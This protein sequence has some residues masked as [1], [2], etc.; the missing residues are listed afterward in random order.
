M[1]FL[2]P[3]IQLIF[4][5]QKIKLLLV[6]LVILSN[7]I[8][9][10][11]MILFSV[12]IAIIRNIAQMCYAQTMT[13]LNTCYNEKNVLKL[14]VRQRIQLLPQGS[15]IE[16]ID[17]NQLCLEAKQYDYI[18]LYQLW[19][20]SIYNYI[21]INGTPNQTND[22]RELEN[23]KEYTIDPSLGTVTNLYK[24]QQNVKNV[25]YHIKFLGEFS[26]YVPRDS[27]LTS[28]QTRFLRRLSYL[29]KNVYYDKYD[30]EGFLIAY[31]DQRK[32]IP[33]AKPWNYFDNEAMN[34]IKDILFRVIITQHKLDGI[35]FLQ[36]SLGLYQRVL[37]DYYQQEILDQGT[38]RLLN[39]FYQNLQIGSL[40]ITLFFMGGN[41]N[42]RLKSI[43]LNYLQQVYVQP[44]I[45]QWNNGNFTWSSRP[46][47]TIEPNNP[48]GLTGN[49]NNMYGT[50]V[51]QEMSST[52]NSCIRFNWTNIVLKYGG[53]AVGISLNAIGYYVVHDG[54]TEDL[55]PSGNWSL[56]QLLD[57][58][59]QRPS[60]NFSSLDIIEVQFEP[61]DYLV[62]F[63]KYY[64]QNS[65]QIMFSMQRDVNSTTIPYSTYK[66]T[67]LVADAD[68]KINIA[69]PFN[70]NPSLK[71]NDLVILSHIN[72]TQ[73]T[74]LDQSNY[75]AAQLEP[76]I[77]QMENNF[78]LNFRIVGL[79]GVQNAG[80]GVCD[81]DRMIINNHIINPGTMGTGSYVLITNGNLWHNSL[82]INNNNVGKTFSRLNLMSVTF[83]KSNQSIVIYRDYVFLYTFLLN[84]QVKNL[85]FCT[86]MNAQGTVVQVEY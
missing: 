31:N 85:N 11:L 55:F 83:L 63:R 38:P 21:D 37:V 64:Q 29:S 24:F 71:F 16:N 50:Q 17:A 33:Y 82:P 39:D 53:G 43:L 28:N 51:Q 20:P 8:V 56:Y 62:R 30:D 13:S 66:F 9:I 6:M 59:R 76:S 40:P 80:V 10:N 72:I 36:P 5:L 26:F 75:Y 58:S 23:I 61:L 48:K 15:T 86:V 2:K 47:S 7:L 35:V 46:E 73:N 57:P 1:I 44:T 79:P 84:D 77:N 4:Q 68:F 52:L 14:D 42:L 67:V 34:D 74:A 60:F 22:Y 69:F 54:Y 27:Y 18:W 12:Y 25:C 65:T 78:T 81:K 19:T 70:F 3:L 32:M 49:A 45:N 41:D